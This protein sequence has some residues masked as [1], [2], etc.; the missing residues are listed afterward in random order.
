MQDLPSAVVWRAKAQRMPLFR[1][2]IVPAVARW[3]ARSHAAVV[4]IG[5]P[6]AEKAAGKADAIANART[7]PATGMAD[8]AKRRDGLVQRLRAAPGCLDRFLLHLRARAAARHRH[9][10]RG[11]GVR[12]GRRPRT[13]RGADRWLGRH[14][15]GAG[16]GANDPVGV[17]QAAI[18][19]QQWGGIGHAV[20]GRER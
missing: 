12:R 5:T 15:G 18:V 6:Y 9:R 2:M 16:L 19:V 13:N 1:T 8:R 20:A 10:D 14:A 17:A 11:R 4:N 3:G 7:T